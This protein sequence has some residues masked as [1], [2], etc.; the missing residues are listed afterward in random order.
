[1]KSHLCNH[2]AVLALLF[3]I[4]GTQAGAS[5]LWLSGAQE[6]VLWRCVNHKASVSAPQGFS[7]SIGAVVP[8]SVALHTMPSTATSIVPTVEPYAYA[9]IDGQLLLVDPKARTIAD[10]IER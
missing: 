5:P 2:M 3:A 10:V 4:G 6:Q 8:R 7:P 1:M 9:V